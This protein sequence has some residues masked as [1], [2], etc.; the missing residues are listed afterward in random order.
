MIIKLLKNGL[1]RRRFLGSA[2]SVA[3]VA[4]V[5][6]VST[7]VLAAEKVIKI[8]FL[9][10]LTG[11][12]AAWGKPGLDG[13]Q[14]WAEKINAAGGVKLARAPARPSSSARTGSSSS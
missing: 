9:A 1:S 2:A 8:G 11:P 13:C 14:I 4:A 6:G 3:G 5:S 7:R 12:V 10:P